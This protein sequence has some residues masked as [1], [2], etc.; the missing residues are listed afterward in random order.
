MFY[1]QHHIGDFLKDTGNLSDAQAM[2]YLRLIW[3][4]YDS[5]SPL[6]NDPDELAFSI[7]SDAATVSLILKHYFAL[8]GEFWIHKRIES[9]IC[10]YHGK[11]ERARNS[12]NARWNNTKAMRTHSER[13]AKASKSDAN[14]EPITN[15]Q[16]IHLLSVDKRVG[17]DKSVNNEYPADFEMAWA[18]YPKRSNAN[19]KE[20]FK[21]W[22]ARVR[23]GADPLV[24]MQGAARY[25]LY[26][27]A[28][29]TQDQYIKQPKTFF[30]PDEHYL[31]EW[32]VPDTQQSS[33]GKTY[34]RSSQ[35]IWGA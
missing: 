16:D 35:V 27:E 26:C 21:A 6:P 29:K 1:Y 30:G 33:E 13:N 22:N 4:Y 31:E 2:T 3:L 23:Q 14:Q 32:A 15:N 12:A 8:E 20:T 5:E 10:K 18:A 11:K 19:K 9:E 25:K 7:R 17:V 24:M 34:R 28:M